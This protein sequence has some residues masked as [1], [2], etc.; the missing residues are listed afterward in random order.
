MD[1]FIGFL[2]LGLAGMILALILIL[3]QLLVLKRMTEEETYKKFL[4]THYWSEL[5]NEY[6]KVIRNKV[7]EDVVQACGEI[8]ERP[9][10][11]LTAEEKKGYKRACSEV[12][13]RVMEA[14]N[15]KE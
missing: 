3:D 6:I 4:N 2:A 11:E 10:E 9:D 15:D 7:R 13:W 14:E 8:A 12:I 1:L 5:R